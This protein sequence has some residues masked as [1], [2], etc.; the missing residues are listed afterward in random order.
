MLHRKT[1]M[2]RGAVIAAVVAIS[3]VPAL[4]SS[5]PQRV[6]V[7]DKYLRPGK[8]TIKKGTRVQWSWHGYLAHN[9]TAI[10]GPA[11]FHSRSQ[12][13]GTYRHSFTR[14]GTYHVV[15]TLHPKQMKETVVVK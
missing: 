3:S 11:K 10:S 1:A 5:G 4:A 8:I 13:K 14:R 6:K 9:V 2:W 15:C 12:V 7:G